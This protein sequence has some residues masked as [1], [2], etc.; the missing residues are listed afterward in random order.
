MSAVAGLLLTFGLLLYIFS[1]V[2]AESSEEKSRAT[3]LRERK[4]AVYENLRDL[5]F[6]YKAG[7]LSDADY[8]SLR[9]SLESEAAA[10]LAEIERLEG[11][12]AS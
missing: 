4:D 11:V 7:K 9:N 3:Y 5:N 12:T 2:T 1:G 6:E 8:E 10:I